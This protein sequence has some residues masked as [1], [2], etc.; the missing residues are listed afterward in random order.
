MEESTK[1]TGRMTNETGQATKG[2]EMAIHTLEDSKEARRTVT[3]LIIGR[4]VK[5]MKANG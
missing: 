1:E 3:E 5:S 2:T 4:L